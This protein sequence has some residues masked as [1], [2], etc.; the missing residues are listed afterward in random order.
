MLSELAK[1]HAHEFPSARLQ[2]D[3]TT[4]FS[5]RIANVVSTNDGADSGRL[6]HKAAAAE[7]DLRT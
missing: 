6:K 3:P 2:Y 4:G 1:V 7:L 5:Y